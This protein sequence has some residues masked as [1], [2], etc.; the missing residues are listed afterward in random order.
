MFL[1]DSVMRV[2]ALRAI[3]RA[4]AAV[5]AFPLGPSYGHCPLWVWRGPYS[6]HVCRRLLSTLHGWKCQAQASLRLLIAWFDVISHHYQNS[7]TPRKSCWGCRWLPSVPGYSGTALGLQAGFRCDVETPVSKKTS[8]ADV[9]CRWQT[10]PGTTDLP[11]WVGRRRIQ[12][13]EGM[14]KL[15]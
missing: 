9:H 10:T 4:N 6:G 8:P 5:G 3:C 1:C 7:T 11:G 15:R 12:Q 13:E 2:W 14:E